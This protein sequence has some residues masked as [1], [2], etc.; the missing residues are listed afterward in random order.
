M[1]C[2][3][4]TKVTVLCGLVIIALITVTIYYITNHH[5]N[6]ST[7]SGKQMNAFSNTSKSSLSK[8]QSSTNADE[9]KHVTINP[10]DSDELKQRK[11]EY[12]NLVDEA[13]REDSEYERKLFS[14]KATK[15]DFEDY[16]KSCVESG[17]KIASLG[18]NPKEN[19]TADE[20]YLSEVDGYIDDQ[21]MLMADFKE[22]NNDKEYKL[23]LK[24]KEYLENIK[25]DYKDGKISA[26]EALKSFTEQY[27]IK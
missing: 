6:I 7:S 15:Q 17:N 25:N 2:K 10:S 27:N 8:E 22:A 23:A 18:I 14:G 12:N 4:K 13:K 26:D 5:S 11:Q 24:R 16:N 19:E 1:R 21:V 20:K 9:Y 3:M